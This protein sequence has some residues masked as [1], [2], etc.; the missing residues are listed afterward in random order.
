MKTHPFR[1]VML[2]L[3]IV[4]LGAACGLGLQSP[5]EVALEPTLT[6]GSDPCLQ[7]NWVMSNENVNTLMLSLTPVP[8]ILPTGTL[9]M[10]FNGDD[11]SYGS[12]GLT[13]RM[14]IP[15]GYMEADAAFLFSGAFATSGGS[16][17][18][19]QTTYSVEAFTWR[20]MIDGE[21][22]EAT[23]PNAI[24]F[25]MPGN[26]PYLCDANILS[27]STTSTTGDS[28]VLTFFRQP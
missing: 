17:E 19:G 13:I 10:S 14:D 5:A 24:A 12:D 26:G 9:V 21:M 28:V 2:F 20:A 7:G 11:F 22:E 27:F 1:N 15:G 4:I 16:I 18:F 8:L 23:G 25:P 3:L 6:G